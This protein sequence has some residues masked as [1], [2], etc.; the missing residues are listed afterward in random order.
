[1]C[2]R[3]FNHWLQK[4]TALIALSNQ[5]NVNNTTLVRLPGGGCCSSII[6]EYEQQLIAH[7]D[8]KRSLE[9]MLT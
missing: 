3:T 2:L 4:L 6:A 9:K 5:R 1:M 8:E 7:F